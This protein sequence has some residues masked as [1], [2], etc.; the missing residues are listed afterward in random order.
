MRS[1]RADESI[2]LTHTSALVTLEKQGAMSAGD[3]AAFE[4]V[5]P[6]SMTK[7]LGTLEQRGLV[8]REVDPSDR[9]CAIIAITDS[10]RELLLSERRRRDALLAQ[11]LARLTTEERAALRAV[12]PIFDK[13]AAE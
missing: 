10:G 3:L 5:Q 12:I 8:K 9:R 6:P 11:R 1:Q 4:R 13:L 7:I 2:T